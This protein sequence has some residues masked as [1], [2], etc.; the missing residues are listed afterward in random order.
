MTAFTLTAG[1]DNFLGGSGA[2]TFSGPGG[3][4][5]TLNG[6]G[7]TD[8]FTIDDNQIGTIDGGAGTDTVVETQN[9]I[10]AN[11]AFAGVEK[12]SLASGI[13]NLF[14]NVSQLGAFSS[15][16][17]N[18]AFTDFYFFL[19]GAGGVLSFATRF[20]TS[21]L[22]HVEAS[23]TTSGVTITGTAHDDDFLGSGF[24]D[25]FRGGAGSDTIFGGAGN[26]VLDG[27]AGA[28][29]LRGGAD[30]DTYYVD[31]AGDVVDESYG[32]G[33]GIDVVRSSNISV[34]LSD[35]VHYMGN[36]E[37]VILGG[38][39]N[40]SA[41][42]NGLK[43]S[44]T[45]N[46]G[47]NALNGGADDDILNGG[48]GADTMTGGTGND[49]FYV[50]DAADKVVEAVGG[51]TDVVLTSVSYKLSAA[52]E[53]ETLRTTNA[54][55]VGAIDLT[56]S[57]YD[58]TI[59]GNAGN[60]V[61]D[62]KDGADKIY[63]YDGADTL[64]GGLGNDMLTGGLGND[65]FLFGTTLSI[66]NIDRINDFAN[67]VGNDDTIAL[68]DAIFTGVTGAGLVAGGFVANTTGLAGDADD[69]IIYQMNTG[70]LFYDADG[71]GGD[72]GT[73]FALVI[74]HPTLTASDFLVV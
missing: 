50:D 2:D 3:G 44:L 68:D 16:A 51:G 11:L 6:A 46:T 41:T 22:L 43:N 74:G 57:D 39:G 7:G 60:N 21:T 8:T 30:N 17:V 25:T 73:Q 36:V 35:A 70:K 12:L 59:Q 48:A 49:T 54:A 29:T 15:I 65:K 18:P 56:G 34:N 1:I 23:L 28:D 9:E 24:V 26:D 63:G 61:L 53:V 55:G 40:L 58:N 52:A 10:N 47:N 69:R 14:A 32:G 62:G 31:N 42:G 27:E 66:N 5:D 64:A 72:E 67:L 37:N 20:V 33:S 13:S 19:Q 38:A 4:S 71:L 45:G